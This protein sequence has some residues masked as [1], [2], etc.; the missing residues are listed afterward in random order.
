MQK[1]IR[2][3]QGAGGVVDMEV[4]D[5]GVSVGDTTSQNEYLVLIAH[6]GEFKEAP[7]IGVGIEDMVGDED[8]RYWEREI[9][10]NLARIGINAKGIEVQDGQL[11][12]T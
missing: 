4:V 12:I 11:I 5:G 7:M 8:G 6:K 1:G 3:E 9:V 2:L 10:E